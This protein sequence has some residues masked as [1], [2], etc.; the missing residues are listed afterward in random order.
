MAAFAL[1]LNT[2]VLGGAAAVPAASRSASTAT[3]RP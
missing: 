3:G 1:N 2:N